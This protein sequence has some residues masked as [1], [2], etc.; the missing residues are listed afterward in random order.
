[1]FNQLN[2]YIMLILNLPLFRIKRGITYEG[3][4]DD[5]ILIFKNPVMTIYFFL[6]LFFLSLFFLL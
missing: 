6:C 2:G 4:K 3:K 5:R 1:M